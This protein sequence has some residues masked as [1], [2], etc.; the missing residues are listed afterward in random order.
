MLALSCL[1]FLTSRWHHYVGVSSALICKENTLYRYPC[2]QTRCYMYN[3]IIYTF[4]SVLVYIWWV[5]IIQAPK[6]RVILLKLEEEFYSYVADSTRVKPYKLP[7]W[8]SYHRMLAHR[9]VLPSLW[10][11]VQ[12]YK[13]VASLGFT[14][15]HC[16]VAIVSGS[17]RQLLVLIVVT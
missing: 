1:R 4:Q 11:S 8:D 16:C 9:Y 12:P 15:C 14:L 6:N 13:H 7:P 3:I 5:K 10:V 2:V 17:I